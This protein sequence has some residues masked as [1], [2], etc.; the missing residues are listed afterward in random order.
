MMFNKDKLI[1]CIVIF[2]FI[3]VLNVSSGVVEVFHEALDAENKGKSINK[4]KNEEGDN[5]SLVLDNSGVLDLEFFREH[6]SRI[7]F[8]ARFFLTQR[9]GV[10]YVLQ[11][12]TNNDGYVIKY[13]TLNVPVLAPQPLLPNRYSELS[14]MVEDS[15]ATA[16]NAPIYQINSSLGSEGRPSL[17][18]AP[19]QGERF[20]IFEI[21]T[22]WEHRHGMYN[23][24]NYFQVRYSTPRYSQ[25]NE[26]S[27]I[28]VFT[29]MQNQGRTEDPLRPRLRRCRILIYYGNSSGQTY[30]IDT[31][32]FPDFSNSLS[33]R[34]GTPEVYISNDSRSPMS[35]FA[36]HYLTPY[37]PT[38]RESEGV[39][40]RGH[41]R[42]FQLFYRRSSNEWSRVDLP[43]EWRALL[44]QGNEGS[45]NNFDIEVTDSGFYIAFWNAQL[46]P[47][48]CLASGSEEP[49]YQGQLRMAHYILDDTGASLI[50]TRELPLT[51]SEVLDLYRSRVAAFAAEVDPSRGSIR[52]REPRGRSYNT[53][54]R[55]Q[56]LRQAQ[57]DSHSPEASAEA[58]TEESRTNTGEAECLGGGEASQ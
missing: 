40:V 15:R 53:E 55:L 31:E 3:K 54:G 29:A 17:M 24:E 10:Y 21:N 6:R 18:V 27:G 12:F 57:E 32:D 44:Q 26:F 19:I 5:K 11:Y 43:E 45:E 33:S 34:E 20:S 4:V 1:K 7:H 14:P 22:A 39:S 48:V 30:Q 8:Y 58:D 51:D 13:A 46:V 23:R 25:Q 52:F 38:I 9:S 42:H 37:E 16:T 41:N 28:H 49:D 2:F 47:R 50:E 35:L 56:R 36:V